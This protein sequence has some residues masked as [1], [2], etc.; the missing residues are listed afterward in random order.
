MHA[1]DDADCVKTLC[2]LVAASVGAGTCIVIMEVVMD[3]TKA[4]LLTTSFDLQM[5]MGTRG[6]ENP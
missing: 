6:R 4:D 2:N 3:E 1:F 5:F